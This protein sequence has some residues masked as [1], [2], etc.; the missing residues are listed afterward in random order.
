MFGIFR[1]IIGGYFIRRIILV[2]P[3]YG[4]DIISNC[5]CIKHMD[6]SDGLRDKIK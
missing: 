3:I 6:G 1:G 5:L 4:S 2:A